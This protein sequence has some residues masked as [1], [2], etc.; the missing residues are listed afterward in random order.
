MN[1]LARCDLAAKF[2]DCAKRL[3]RRTRIETRQK[4]SACAAFVTVLLLQERHYRQIPSRASARNPV[5]VSTK[6]RRAQ[7]LR[8]ALQDTAGHA[9]VPRLESNRQNENRNPRRNCRSSSLAP[10]IVRKSALVMSPF[11]FLKCGELDKLAASARNC[12]FKRSVRL[13]VRNRLKS[14]L[15]EPGPYKMLRPTVP[16][17]TRVTG[18]NAEGS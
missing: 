10:V 9:S 7:V 17:P 1:S 5:P 18:A 8:P 2:S 13:N 14:K 12:K 16:Y 15:T 3:D 11:G 4:K 6:K